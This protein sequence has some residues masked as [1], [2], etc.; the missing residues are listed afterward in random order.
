MKNFAAEKSTPTERVLGMTWMTDNDVFV[1]STQF[2]EDLLPL[3]SCD[4]VPT[5]R[6]VLRV[7][8]SYFDPLGIISNYTIHGRILLQDIWRS[9]AN[10]DDPI[11]NED[12]VSWQRWVLLAPQLTKVK[13]PRCY[14]PAYDPNSFETLQL[15]VFV[16]AGD[17]AYGAVAYFRIVDRGIPRCALVA[18]KAKVA[19]LK[20]LSTPR[21]EL[22]ASVIGI[23]LMKMIEKN[24]SFTI[25]KRFLWTDSTTVLSWLHAD[26]RKY[27]Q[28]V[29]LRVSEILS[30]SE[31][32]EWYWIATS[33][34]VADK[35]TKWGHGPDF[36]SESEWYSGPSFLLRPETEWTI[37]QPHIMDPPEE[38]KAINVQRQRSVFLQR[39]NFVVELLRLNDF[40]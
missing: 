8:M 33:K 21:S 22:N 35:T 5:K 11:T 27:R 3:L 40:P 2:R 32:S 28:Y 16:D 10:W 4:T 6:Q 39:V 38:L 20:P 19:P 12:F 37:K 15:H 24:H 7:V 17:Q 18:A 14:F 26:P 29:A 1:F 34:N 30:E 25:N 31:I 13:I 36:D 23:R 9:K